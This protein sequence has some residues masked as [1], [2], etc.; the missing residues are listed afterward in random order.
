MH[1]TIHDENVV[2]I[3][4]NKIGTEAAEQLKYNMDMSFHDMLKVPM[5]AAA[6]VGPNWGYWSSDIWEEMKKGNF[7]PA[8]FNKDY[9]ETH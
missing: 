3:P 2:S 1:L 5:K 4:F 8:L 9:K 6:E 7:D